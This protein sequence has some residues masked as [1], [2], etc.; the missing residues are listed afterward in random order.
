MYRG[1]GGFRWCAIGCIKWCR[2]IVIVCESTLLN[3]LSKFDWHSGKIL[4]IQTWARILLVVKCISPYL[5]WT[6][7]CVTERPANS[8]NLVAAGWERK[9]LFHPVKCVDEQ[10]SKM[11]GVPPS[12]SSSPTSESGLRVD[13]AMLRNFI[14]TPISGKWVWLANLYFERLLR[15]KAPGYMYSY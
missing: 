8:R 14:M 2:A 15:F 5:K 7:F 13:Q 4:A 6:Q 11:W 3:F 12:P 10:N 9:Q 1:R